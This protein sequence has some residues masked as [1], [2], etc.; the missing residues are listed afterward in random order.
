MTNFL[1]HADYKIYVKN[2]E[3]GGQL[4]ILRFHQVAFAPYDLLSSLH[5][6]ELEENMTHKQD[7]QKNQ[8]I[9]K[10]WW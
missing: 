7:S 10:F 3:P 9:Y 8:N 6:A 2:V 4:S 1:T 5:Y